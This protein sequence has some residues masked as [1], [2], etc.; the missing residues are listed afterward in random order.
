M[1]MKF[2]II[3]PALNEADTIQQ[4][5]SSLQYLRQSGHEIILVDG[6]SKDATNFISRPL[7]NNIIISETGR[8]KQMNLG[9]RM[10]TG[11]ILL[12]LH[13]D[14]L[15][16]DNVDNIFTGIT[17][18]SHW[19]RFDIKLSGTQKIYRLIE[20]M[21]NLR[22]R[23]SGIATGDQAIFM[24]RDLFEKVNGFPEMPLMEDVAISKKLKEIHSPICLKEK[25]ITSSRRWET[26]G[27]VNTVLLMWKLRLQYAIGIPPDKLLSQY[28]QQK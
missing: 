14:T 25:V 4:T 9:A 22:S 19:G 13:A 17:K 1:T 7:V 16:P 5:L 10:A 26:R 15:L 2:S 11:K 23:L 27:I 18:D 20:K 3:I 21:I 8:A 12:F 28:E 24:T 6:G